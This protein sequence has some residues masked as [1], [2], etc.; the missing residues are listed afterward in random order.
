MKGFVKGC[1]ILMIILAVAGIVLLG[2]AVVKGFRWSSFREVSQEDNFHIGPLYMYMEDPFGL[3]IVWGIP[4]EKQNYSSEENSG[5]VYTFDPSQIRSLRIDSGSGD[6]KVYSRDESDGQIKVQV[7]ERT[8][9]RYEVRQNGDELDI[10]GKNSWNG[11]RIGR[12]QSSE[13]ALYVPEGMELDDLEFIVGAGDLEVD[14]PLVTES[15]NLDVGTGDMVISEK[16][17]VKGD[18]SIDVGTGDITIDNINCLGRLDSSC[19]VGDCQL[20]GSVA[21]DITAKCGTGDMDIALEG[22]PHRYNYEL[23]CG[24][25][26]LYVNGTEY[27][28]LKKNLVIH[29]GD[30]LPDIFLDTGVGDLYFTLD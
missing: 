12:H 3:D 5:A 15:L 22:N 17:I 24:V 6:V 18:T 7:T 28:S 13:V 30:E 26:S 20:R 19:G 25:G 16:L 8:F 14:T 11:I 9:T 23:S 2:T 1:L 29:N 27:S 10:T 21:G 4:Q